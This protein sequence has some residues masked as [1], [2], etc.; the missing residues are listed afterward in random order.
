MKFH[1][2]ILCLL[3]TTISSGQIEKDIN[4]VLLKKDF[5]K[6]LKFVNKFEKEIKHIRIVKGNIREITKGFQEAT[7]EINKG[8]PIYEGVTI[9]CNPRLKLITQ[10]TQIIYFFLESKEM[11]NAPRNFDISS[12]TI[13]KFIDKKRMGELK[14]QYRTTFKISLNEDDLF[15]DTIAVGDKCGLYPGLITKEQEQILNWVKL[16]DTLSLYNWLQSPNTEKQVYAIKGFYYLYLKGMKISEQT[17]SIIS[18]INQKKGTIRT[19]IPCDS[20]QTNIS[21]ALKPY[22]F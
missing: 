20:K 21:D 12:D 14:K 6:L 22:L 16:T 18:V 13:Y 15:I 1:L 2:M 8:Y 5:Q 7:F 17:R 3:I 11:K 4:S 19:C 10:G 9:T